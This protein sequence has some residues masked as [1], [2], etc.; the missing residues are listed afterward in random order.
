MAPLD[1]LL[2]THVRKSHMVM[3]ACLRSAPLILDIAI[4]FQKTALNWA[5]NAAIGM[6]NVAGQLLVTRAIQIKSVLLKDYV[7][8]SK[9]Y[10]VLL[11]LNVF[12]DFV[13]TMSAA[14]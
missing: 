9:G 12:Q 1:A 6:T 8:K 10:H 11:E 4:A 5:K 14:M 7:R 3:V 13:R 2:D